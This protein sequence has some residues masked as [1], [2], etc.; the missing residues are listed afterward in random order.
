MIFQLTILGTA[1]SAPIRE[2]NPSAQV[3]NVHERLFLIDCG[4]GTQMQIRK[5]G[6]K[7]RRINHVFISHLHGDHY[8][9]LAGLMFSW[10]LFGRTEPLHIYA[11]EA[12]KEIMDLQLEA[13]GTKLQYPFIFHALQPGASEILFEDA[14]VR[15]HSFPL[16]HRVPTHGFMF[17]EVRQPRGIH[18]EAIRNLDIP[19]T[20]FNNIK[21]GADFTDANG[22]VH[23]NA[24]LT[25]E[26]P[27]CRS[28]AYCSDTGFHL[29]ITKFIKGADL[30]YHE[31]TFMQDM[32]ANAD[33][34][35]HSTAMQAATIAVKA[36]ARKL[37]IGHFSARYDELEPL[38]EEAQSVFRNTILAEEGMTVSI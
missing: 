19:F 28:F 2:R 8:L 30:V 22:K 33:E 25:H 34:K 4:E 36:E 29:G 20:E 17:R 1:A 11:N 13:S 21:A 15:V 7:G 32:I 35:Q 24:S 5:Y 14:K 31:A 3:L 6:I 18:H 23:S 26:P 16:K 12:L 9:G 38:L 37:L 10:H 27:R